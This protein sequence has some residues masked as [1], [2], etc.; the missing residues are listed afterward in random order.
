MSVLT[1][2]NV[3]E[4]VKTTLNEWGEVE[5]EAIFID[6][7]DG[8]KKKNVK[9]NKPFL[10]PGGPLKLFSLVKLIGPVFFLL[11]LSVQCFLLINQDFVCFLI[12]C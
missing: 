5:E 9:L 12:K 8:G 3:F 7:E 6:E 11:L 2:N 4:N 1:G 10:T